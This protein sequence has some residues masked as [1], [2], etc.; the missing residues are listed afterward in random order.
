LGGSQKRIDDRFNDIKRQLD[1]YIEETR[2]RSSKA[3]EETE[4]KRDR[5][6]ED[7]KKFSA[8]E[9][10]V[11]YAQ[12]FNDEAD[13]NKDAIKKWEWLFL[14]SLFI[15]ITVAL[16]LFFFFLPEVVSLSKDISF[17][18]SSGVINTPVSSGNMGISWLLGILLVKLFILSTVA[19]GIG[20]ALKNLNAQNHLYSTNKFKANALAS[21]Q[22]FL[23][24]VHDDPVVLN[25]I[26]LQVSRAVY[27]TD[28]SG[29][30]SKDDSSR[31][32]L[33]KL[34][35]FSKFIK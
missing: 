18:S 22:A 28:V 21:F 31:L 11:K 16:S 3:I 10:L 33:N 19:V 14:L 20:Y 12:I 1:Q 9:T 2:E 27:S 29:Y 25:E 13:R 24:A 17:V 15:G 30:L 4:K 23:D 34:E 5:A 26:I 7:L 35:T 32:L 6:L 8:K